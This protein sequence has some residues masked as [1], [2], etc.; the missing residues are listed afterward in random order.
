MYQ[1]SLHSLEFNKENRI[2][3]YHHFLYIITGGIT[4]IKHFGDIT[5]SRIL[6]SIFVLSYYLTLSYFS[7]T[8]LMV[9]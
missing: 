3:A 7:L 4:N 5:T 1:T 2:S 8:Y 6:R 9:K